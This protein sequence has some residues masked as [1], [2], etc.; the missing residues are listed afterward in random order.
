MKKWNKSVRIFTTL[1]LLV[2][3]MIP[4]NL[5]KAIAPDTIIP[6]PWPE[7]F[8]PYTQA[9]GTPIFDPAG[10]IHPI[11]VDIT[12]GVDRGRGKL[13]SMYVA[14]DGSNFFVRLRVK[15]DPFDRKGGFLSS[16]WLVKLAV[17]GQARA[18]IGLNGKSPHIDYVYVANENGTNVKTVYQT[19]TDGGSIVPGT[20]ITP[21]EN[22]HYFLDFQVPINKITEMAPE[23][24]ATQPVQ[25]FFGTSKAANLSV[26]NKEWMNAGNTENALDFTGLKEM[27]L[28]KQPLNV[29]IDGGNSKL[30][31]AT[32]N[33]IK[34][35]STL[36]NGTVNL[37]INNEPA[38]PVTISNHNWTYTLPT[39]ITGSNGTYQ[40]VATVTDN[41]A[42][43]TASQDIVIVNN[44]NTLLIDGGAA[45]ITNSKT[46]TLTGTYAGTNRNNVKIKVKIDG[47]EV[48]ANA[49]RDSNKLTWSYNAAL[50][51]P[52]DGKTYSIKVEWTGTGSNAVTY[53]TTTQ[54][55]TYK[56]GTQA[57]AVNVAITGITGNANPS[58]T[59]TSSGAAAVELRVD[60]QT[61]E[62][63]NPDSNGGWT[64]PALEKPLTMGIHTI[65]AIATNAN[66]NSSTATMDHQVS[67]AAITIDNGSAVTLNDSNPTFRG[68]TNAPAG[69]DVKVI[70]DGET[71]YEFTTKVDNGRWVIAV[72]DDKKLPDGTY[73]VTATINGASTSQQLTIDTKTSVNIAAPIDGSDT[74]ETRPTFDGTA[75]AR[76]T[77]ELLVTDQNNQFVLVK[78]LSTA[79]GTDTDW[80]WLYTMTD[81]LPLGFYKIKATASDLYGNEAVDESTFT[82]SART[83]SLVKADDV[84][85][86]V[87]NGTSLSEAMAALGTKIT[88]NL[89]DGKTIEI[90]ITWSEN[91]SPSYD[92]AKAG[93]YVFTGTFG[94]LPNGIDN[95]DKAAA[96]A[97]IITVLEPPTVSMN[98]VDK[99]T[100]TV[101]NGTS[102]D[103]AVAALGTTVEVTLENGSKVEVPIVW[104]E[105]SS[106]A[107]DGTTAGDYVF[108]GTFGPLPDGIDNEKELSAPTGTVTVLAPQT[109]KISSVLDITKTVAIGTTKE[110]ATAA[111]GTTVEVTLENG[112]KVEVPIVWSDNSS[113]AY[114]GNAAGS[115]VFTGTFGELP[116]GINNDGKIAAPTGTVT[117]LSNEADIISYSLPEQTK[118]AVINTKDRTIFV[119]VKNG[120]N[121]DSLAASFTLS[122]KAQG[123]KIGEVTQ[124]SGQTPNNFSKA[125]SYLVKAEDGTEKVWTVFVSVQEKTDTPDS[126]G[127]VRA[128]DQKLNG[129]SEPGAT[130][131]VKR[132]GVTLGTTTAN[133][134]GNW[135][136]E[137]SNSLFLSAGEKLIITATAPGK[138]ESD[139]KEVLI[140]RAFSNEKQIITTQFG[141]VNEEN[142][143]VSVPG[144]TKVS[145]LLAGLVI[146]N[147]AS[148]EIVDSQTGEKIEN[149]DTTD[150]SST[151][152]IRITAEDGSVSEHTI[153]IQTPAE[154]QLSSNPDS[155]VGDGASKATLTAV[156]KDLKG[157]P[158]PNV[159][160][161]FQA[162]I[163]SLSQTTA[164]TNE[165]GEATVLLTAPTIEGTVPVSKKVKATVVDAAKGISAEDEITVTFQPPIIVGQVLDANGAP[166]ANAKV[167]VE[168]NDQKIEVATDSNGN[169]QITV[170]RGG[171]YTV[172]IEVHS[173][174]GNG[175]VTSVYTQHASVQAKGQNESFKSERKV[176]GKLLIK[177]R[178]NTIKSMQEM[179]PGATLLVNVLND[180]NGEITAKIDQEGTYELTGFASNKTYQVAFNVEVDG[181]K[182]AGKLSEITVGNDGQLVIQHEL[183]DPFGL[184][185]DS[186][187]GKL[188]P[189]VSM[190]LY[191][192]DTDLNKQNGRTPDTLVTLPELVGFPPNKNSNPQFTTDLLADT[193]ETGNYAWMVFAN[194]DYYI[195]GEKD[196]YVTFDSRKDATTNLTNVDS[197]IQNG[198]IHIGETMM[199]Y[200]F[201][202]DPITKENPATPEEPAKPG[203][204]SNPGDTATPQEPV[205]DQ[206]VENQSQTDTP[207]QRQTDVTKQNKPAATA[208]TL[209][210]TA[211]SMYNT[212]LYGLILIAVGFIVLF[213]KNRRRRNTKYQT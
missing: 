181:Q 34:G 188:L 138:V 130:I 128:G 184:V 96:P 36:T 47:V 73:T 177:T 89:E 190:K 158:I 86:T 64:V 144:D 134:S 58:F 210:K 148:L 207:A 11:D 182:L 68:N 152:I 143:L 146:S 53:A 121:L 78:N 77:V 145:E 171:D 50:N 201:A 56:E 16:V 176:S 116:N 159:E 12:S 185:T 44:A 28:N 209:P 124:I 194:A 67:S 29:T 174:I 38:I 27:A 6:A 30:Y 198:I 187:T 37:N 91:S 202:M 205:K 71:H 154:L 75:E 114:D 213:A 119:E 105:S 61:V 33:Q 183:I 178:N 191:W 90:P 85:K 172:S 142:N 206:P 59:G 19:T 99:I 106:P 4:S 88:V 40:A 25:F 2:M 15:G 165:Q 14:S 81:E 87:A 79:P 136:L 112:T 51:T 7:V 10:E 102:K 69:S 9:D 162:E 21:A 84:R 17:G 150:V 151:M 72:P 208:N 160:V 200:D 98:H 95:D 32:D 135:T 155:L 115:Y 26:I 108:T 118:S 186:A 62:I 82:I 93:N 169:Y 189:G 42:T 66:G 133:D 83:V 22:G 179:F 204:S 46:P 127:I 107:Y 63:V 212:M 49:P 94:Q 140:E 192:A 45:A 120:T 41:G 129:T 100:K 48:S 60:G 54:Q 92:G 147:Y 163:G 101:A 156:L 180:P 149:P 132:D 103:A 52:V 157:N 166:I 126:S 196:G 173:Q 70:I 161:Q 111:L 80:N 193:E 18:T 153:S 211:T 109:V 123:V 24:T 170:P 113:P 97:G 164:K 137:L 55:L 175:Q 20:R 125:I 131:I 203:D 76:S 35:K 74:K 195:I 3:T 141:Q 199:Q 110:A 122:E 57:A 139:S 23:I 39:A 197:S 104:G 43:D 31:S 167:W 168:V 117:I 8:T 65:T 1:L 13:P 5:A